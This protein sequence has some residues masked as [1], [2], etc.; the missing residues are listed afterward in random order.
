MT[1]LHVAPHAANRQQ[2]LGLLFELNKLACPDA[3]R[4]YRLRAGIESD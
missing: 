3:Q 4:R 2:V 1:T